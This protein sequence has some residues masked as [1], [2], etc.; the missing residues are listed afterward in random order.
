MQLRPIDR[1]SPN[2]GAR[3][4]PAR[5]DM[6]VLHYTGMTTAADALERLCDPDA[7][8][9]AHYVVEENGVIWQL[10]PENRQAFHAG[11][12]CWEGESDLNAVSLGI[13]IV[14]P[15]HEWGY[16][17]FPEIQMA[18][19][20]HLCRDLVARYSIP[21]HRVVGHSDIAPE[22][23]SDPGELFDWARLARAG[24]GIWPPARPAPREC[25]VNPAESLGDLSFIGYCVTAESQTPALVAF[26]R[27]F[28]QSCCDG[29]L[30]TETAVRL[31]EVREAFAASRASAGSAAH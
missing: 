5:I 21:P 17:P 13:E 2:H 4:E 14:N 25:A 16:S 27:R 11:V 30:D 28:R 12:S 1:S 9:S 23:K 22:R 19:V 18:S 8:V 31:S 7:R 29:R 15:G 24:I 26:Q 20:E 6:L 10:V 3:P